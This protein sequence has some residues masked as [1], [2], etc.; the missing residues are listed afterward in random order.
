MKTGKLLKADQDVAAEW[1]MLVSPSSCKC[2]LSGGSSVARADSL[3]RLNSVWGRK[4]VNTI[5]QHT[6]MYTLHSCG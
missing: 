6:T 3:L 5:E 2:M 1:T 4:Q